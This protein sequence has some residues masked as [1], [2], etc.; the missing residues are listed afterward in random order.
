LLPHTGQGAAQ[1]I[2]D[3][4][5][6]GQALRTDDHVERALR[7]YERDRGQKTATL[8]KQGRR[9]ARIMGSTSP[10]LNYMRELV[11]QTIPVQPL[12]KVFASINRRAGTDI[13]R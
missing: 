3:A 1:A 8:L 6:L 11:I 13:D 10:I 9:T 7:V 2:V 12:F 4:V 5:A